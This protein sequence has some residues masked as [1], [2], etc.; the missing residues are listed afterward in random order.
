MGSASEYAEL[1]QT[2]K[3]KIYNFI[4]RGNFKF[5]LEARKL[6]IRHNLLSFD[7]PNLTDE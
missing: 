7:D 3:E 4:F 6:A 1:S 2:D 5:G